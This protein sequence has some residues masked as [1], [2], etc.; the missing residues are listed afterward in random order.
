MHQV[1][2]RLTKQHV[3]VGLVSDGVDVGRDL[4]TLL[5]SVELNDLVSINGVEPVGV[6]HHTEET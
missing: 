1:I 3:S 4:M 2:M 6:H 5:A